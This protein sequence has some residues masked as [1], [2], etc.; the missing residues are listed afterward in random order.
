MG[1]WAAAAMTVPGQVVDAKMAGL[2]AFPAAGQKAVTIM[3]N[4]TLAPSQVIPLGPST[5][6]SP[7]YKVTLI[8]RHFS[9][10]VKGNF[11]A[12]GRP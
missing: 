5:P 7:L 9:P 3:S 10:K 11:Q 6:H 8:Y 1:V 12:K 4:Q 2:A